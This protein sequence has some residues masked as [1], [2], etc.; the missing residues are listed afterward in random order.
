MVAH[1]KNVMTPVANEKKKKHGI[2]QPNKI[3]EVNC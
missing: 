2:S 3:T 1:Y